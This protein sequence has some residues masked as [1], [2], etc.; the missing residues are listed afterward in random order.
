M[1]SENVNMQYQIKRHHQHSNH[2][3]LS[4]IVVDHGAIALAGEKYIL[5]PPE[6]EGWKSWKFT[7]S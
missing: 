4:G 6:V 1:C 7:P 3:H 5:E 2:E